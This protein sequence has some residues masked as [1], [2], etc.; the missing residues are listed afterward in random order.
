[1]DDSIALSDS[2]NSSRKIVNIAAG[3]SHTLAL[4]GNQ[5]ICSVIYSLCIY[6]VKLNLDLVTI[7]DRFVIFVS[8]LVNPGFILW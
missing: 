5:H 6:C 8:H 3:E 2:G 1:M 4:A 7:H